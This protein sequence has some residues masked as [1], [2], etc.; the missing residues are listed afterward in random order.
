MS[1][2]IARR[3]GRAAATLTRSRVARGAK[4]RLGRSVG[5]HATPGR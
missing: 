3:L 1:K 5:V 2:Y 4:R